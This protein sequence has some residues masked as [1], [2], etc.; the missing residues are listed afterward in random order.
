MF[1]P[2]NHH[3]A[4]IEPEC[5]P[6]VFATAFRLHLYRTEG[7]VLDVYFKLLDRCDEDVRTIRLA[8][9]Y[10]R[11]K[12]GHRGPV[13]RASL[14]IPGSVASDPHLA[15]SAMLRIPFLDGRQPPFVDQLLQI[16]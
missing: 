4:A 6:T 1:F 9:Q 16:G 14:M 2:G 13:D 11:E 3:V 8:S 15:M 10:C 12:A 5:N 7:G